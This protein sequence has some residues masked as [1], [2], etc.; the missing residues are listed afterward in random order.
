[1]KPEKLLKKGSL[2]RCDR[3][4]QP[5]YLDA[6]GQWM[7]LVPEGR[8]EALLKWGTNPQSL[9]DKLWE[10]AATIGATPAHRSA[11]RQGYREIPCRVQ[12]HSGEWI[13]RALL[14]LTDAAPLA[15]EFGETGLLS[16]VVDL[17]PSPQA[18]PLA[19]RLASTRSQ[20]NEKGQALTRVQTPDGKELDLNWVVN[21]LDRKGWVGSEVSLSE[22]KASLFG[23]KKQNK[24]ASYSEPLSSIR[25]FLGD[26]SENF[27]RL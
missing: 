18:L 3:C 11:R 27:R 6:G 24:V 22:K 17:E 8:L 25:L 16:E 13:E 14:V 12:T 9:S 2:Y 21:F 7:N 1:L 26:G 23:K 10:K 19:V 20:P 5:W 15:P 4:R